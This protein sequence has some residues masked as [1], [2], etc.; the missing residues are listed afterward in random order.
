MPLPR[1]RAAVF[2]MDGLL[3]DSERPVR[4]AWLRATREFGAPIAEPDYLQLVGRNEADSRRWLEAHLGAVCSYDAARARAAALLEDALGITGYAVKAG[5]R[6]VLTALRERA[7]PCV[8]ASSTHRA[9]VELRLR[10]AGLAPFFAGF[11][12]GDEVVHGKPHP[13]LFLL[14]AQRLGHAPADC[15]V[16][17]DSE[18][19]ARAAIAAGMSLVIV[20]DLRRPADD[21]CAASVA[22]LASLHDA[23]VHVGDWFGA[24][25]A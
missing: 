12:G 16:F 14:A 24:P 19:G 25:V 9:E 2:D 18:P 23:Q 11:N 1:F 7:V 13:D 21:A 17:E 22:V 20:P 15:L 5:V 10:Q 8:V 3:L 6:D 4:D